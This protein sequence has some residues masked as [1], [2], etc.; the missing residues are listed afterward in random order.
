MILMLAGGAAV[1]AVVLAWWTFNRLM[2]LDERCNTAFADVDVHLKHRH[3]VIPGLVETVRGF[4]GHELT[5][6]TEV[7]KARAGA[8]RAAGPDMRLEAETQVGQSLNSLL[9]VV[10]H[11]PEL[12]ASSHFRDLRN[13]LIDAENRITAS[14]RFYNLAVDEFNATLRQ[15]P[16]NLIGGFGRLGRRKHFDLGVER[17]LIDEP[18]AFR[19]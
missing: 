10:E 19:F 2:A 4:V 12:Q 18:V 8:L 15:F 9:S 6:L 1:V 3:A 11:Y 16:G 5:V 17:V 14:R 13:Q 7:T